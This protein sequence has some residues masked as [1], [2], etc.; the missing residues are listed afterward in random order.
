[1]KF[2]IAYTKLAESDLEHAS[3]YISQELHNQA[4]AKKLILAA[5]ESAR[6]LSEMPMRHPVVSGDF[7]A[8]RGIRGIAVKNYMMFYTVQEESRTVSIVRFLYGKRD[9]RSLLRGDEEQ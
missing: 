6:S 3:D 7:L 9:W 8:E 1:M 2:K 4:A 5:R